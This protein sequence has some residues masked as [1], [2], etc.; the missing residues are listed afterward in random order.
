MASVAKALAWTIASLSEQSAS[1]APSFVSAVLVTSPRHRVEPRP[2]GCDVGF[3]RVGL[4]GR[5]AGA[6]A[7]AQR[8]RRAPQPGRAVGATLRGGNRGRDLQEE[9]GDVHHPR[10]RR[11][12][13]ASLAERLRQEIVP[14]A[15]GRE[16]THPERE[17][18]REAI[19]CP[20]GERQAL[21]VQ[22]GGLFWV[23]PDHRRE[24]KDQERTGRAPGVSYG[25]TE[26][27]GLFG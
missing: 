12:C 14:P 21:L 26:S 6:Y 17:G 3:V 4:G 11:E 18:G 10:L 5:E 1:Q 19:L 9:G 24:A 2:G 13:E 20:S 8:S 23:P 25:A 16:R 7:L 15:E 22:R 27:Q